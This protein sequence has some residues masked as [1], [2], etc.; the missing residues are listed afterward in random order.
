MYTH[1]NNGDVKRLPDEELI[2]KAY[3]A[4][5]GKDYE[6]WL[7]TNKNYELREP[8]FCEGIGVSG[9]PMLSQW[10]FSR[11]LKAEELYAELDIFLGWRND[12]P[13]PPDLVM[14]EKEKLASKGFD[15]ASFKHRK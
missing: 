15:R 12:N 9:I 2:Q 1:P 4:K 10:H 14:T 6:I 11:I 13:Q 7:P 8:I 5:I 3:P